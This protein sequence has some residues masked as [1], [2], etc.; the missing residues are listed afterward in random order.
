MLG[1][2][3]VKWVEAIQTDLPM[4]W[5]AAIFGP[6]RFGPTQRRLYVKTYL[7]WALKCGHSAKLL[8]NVYYEKRFEQ[9]IDDLRSELN[10]PDIQR[11]IVTMRPFKYD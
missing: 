9:D 11:P 5:S 2:V 3:A 1:E 8:M 10:I 7:P 6:V 4:C